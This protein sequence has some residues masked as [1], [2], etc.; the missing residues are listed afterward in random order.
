MKHA[1]IE[2]RIGRLVVDASRHAE[3]AGLADAIGQALHQRLAGSANDSRAAHG[4]APHAVA[5]RI[6]TRLTTTPG[7]GNPRGQS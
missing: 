6:A 4:D 5:D 2:I 1:G 7:A 3:T